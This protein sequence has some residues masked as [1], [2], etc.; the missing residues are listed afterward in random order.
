L[1]RVATLMDE[2]GLGEA[3]LLA[4]APDASASE[5]QG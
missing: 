2:P 5:R 3:A 4:N 1:Q